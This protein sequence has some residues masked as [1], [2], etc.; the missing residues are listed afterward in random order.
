[1]LQKVVL[2]M[3]NT[4]GAGRGNKVNAGILDIFYFMV[5][6]FNSSVVMSNTV[7]PGVSATDISIFHLF[8]IYFPYFKPR[9][10]PAFSA[11][12]PP[13]VEKVTLPGSGG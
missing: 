12:L 1:M 9:S 6:D 4:G 8:K 10:P 7:T 3:H 13:M 5:V 2:N 11:T